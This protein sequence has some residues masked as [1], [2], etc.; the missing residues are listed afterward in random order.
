MPS[1]FCAQM[2]YV[3]IICTFPRHIITLAIIHNNKV[4]IA[5][6]NGVGPQKCVEHHSHFLELSHLL[7]FRAVQNQ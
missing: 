6:A 1:A 2:N 5:E 7:V 4:D 3:T